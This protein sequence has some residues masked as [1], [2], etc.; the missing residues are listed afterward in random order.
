M[1]NPVRWMSSWPWRSL[2]KDGVPVIISLVAL[3]I[4]IYDRR[5]R[6]ALKARKGEW[7]TLTPTMGGNE[8]IFRGVVE[9]YNRSN[10]ANAIR[11]YH[12]R[13]KQQ[14]GSWKDMESERYRNG[15]RTGTSADDQSFNETPLSLAPYSGVE[16]P[17]QAFVKIIKLRR[18]YEL[19]VKIEIED[20]FGKRY[21]VEVNAVS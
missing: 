6:L 21:C 9:V 5:P 11:G 19:P 13:C 3:L 7:Y 14:D 15:Y 4:V 18:P 16:V 1:L 20:L 12:F 8:V 17:V 10:R 2:V